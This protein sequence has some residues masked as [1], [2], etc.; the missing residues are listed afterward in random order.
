MH[1]P[2]FGT[3]IHGH[4]G[5]IDQ[6]VQHLDGI[7]Q[8]HIDLHLCNF[9]LGLVPD[10]FLLVALQHHQRGVLDIVSE[11]EGRFGGHL[12]DNELSV[13]RRIFLQHRRLFL[14]IGIPFFLS[15][16][17]VISLIV[18]IIRIPSLAFQLGL[19]AKDLNQILVALGASRA[20]I[21]H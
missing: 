10:E 8:G 5:I 2:A 12:D 4:S 17:P 3:L 13:I 21:Q 20:V 14:H 6:H 16:C 9:Y 19:V 7:I 15:L 1:Q 11:C 18:I